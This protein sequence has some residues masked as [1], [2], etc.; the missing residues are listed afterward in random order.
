MPPRHF[1][2]FCSKPTHQ[3]YFDR[4]RSA[5]CHQGIKHRKPRGGGM[6]RSGGLW[7]PTAYCSQAAAL[8]GVSL[9][10]DAGLLC[11]SICSKHGHIAE[12]PLGYR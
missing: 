3:L 10:G 8:M 4:R 12:V 6:L 7:S 2:G 11:S 9:R 5:S 1:G